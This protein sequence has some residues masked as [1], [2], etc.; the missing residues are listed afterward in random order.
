MNIDICS[1]ANGPKTKW[2]PLLPWHYLFP[3][4]RRRG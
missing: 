1:L 2:H 3:Q 4:V